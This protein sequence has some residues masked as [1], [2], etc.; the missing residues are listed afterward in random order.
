MK[1]EQNPGKILPCQNDTVT[2]NPDQEDLTKPPPGWTSS[3]PTRPLE[4]L[5]TAR[6]IQVLQA[7]V[8]GACNAEIAESLNI[9]PETVKTHVKNILHKLKARDRTQAVVIALRASLVSLPD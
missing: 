7:S 8:N 2:P 9:T 1:L 4:S 5:L 6:E 3:E